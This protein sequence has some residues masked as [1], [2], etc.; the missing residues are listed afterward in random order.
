MSESNI[1]R[2]ILRAVC[3]GP[4]RLLRQNAGQGWIGDSRRIDRDTTIHAPA[5]SVIIYNARPFRAAV[6]GLSDL[7]GWRTVQITPEMVGRRIAVYIALEVK[8]PRGRPSAEQKN[9]LR[10]VSEAGGIAIVARSSDEA[11]KG[12]DD[13]FPPE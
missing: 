6:E 11:A 9:F 1:L 13:W 12:L 7:G 10:V 2:E 3:R 8:A 5:G 4:I